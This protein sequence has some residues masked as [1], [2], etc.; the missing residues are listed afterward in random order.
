MIYNFDSLSFQIFTVDRFFHRDGVF[1]VRSKSRPYAALS[2]RVKGTGAFEVAGKR[3]VSQPGSLL[4]LPGNIPYK[5]EYSGSESI[6]VHLT[7]CNY[8]EVEDIVLENAAAVELRFR[9]L[10][11]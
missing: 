1:N 4:F 5:V 2:F 3:F 8:T 9:R 10:L 11:S 7:D 6:V